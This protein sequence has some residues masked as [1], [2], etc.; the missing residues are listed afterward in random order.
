MRHPPKATAIALGLLF[1]CL[2]P[3]T[4]SAESAQWLDKLGQLYERGPFSFDYTMDMKI[5][6]Q[7][8][9][10]TMNGHGEMLYGA[11]RQMRMHLVMSMAIPGMPEP[12][13][14]V[15][16]SVNDGEHTWTEIEHPMMGKQVI[17]VSAADAQRSSAKSGLMNGLGTTNS[18]PLSQIGKL[19]EMFDLLESGGADGLVVLKGPMKE[20]ARD[21]LGPAA[22]LFGDGSELELHLNRDTGFPTLVTLGQ[23]GTPVLTMRTTNLEFL[24]Q[25]EIDADA[26]AYTVPEGVNVVEPL[27]EKSPAPAAG[28]R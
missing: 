22:A 6:Q 19:R 28:G 2:L 15:V 18:D 21:E 11:N 12:M 25:K 20:E 24:S 3:L 27:A 1:T 7:G 16:D 4:A 9:Q 10:M 14:M 8:Q 17:K 23:P 26:F 13:E 5:E